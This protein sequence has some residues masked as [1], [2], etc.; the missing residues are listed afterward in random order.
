[1]VVVAVAADTAVVVE[2]VSPMTVTAVDVLVTWHV[3]VVVVGDL[4]GVVEDI[5]AVAAVVGATVV[6]EE[7]EAPMGEEIVTPVDVQDH[8]A[9]MVVA[10][11][12]ALQRRAAI[13]WSLCPCYATDWMVH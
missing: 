12:V 11:T 6:E 9:T 10:M 4:E 3:I 7:A 5:E 1:V 8:V 2:V 13:V